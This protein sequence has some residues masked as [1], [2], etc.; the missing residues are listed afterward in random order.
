[1]R[2]TET[3]LRQ[4]MADVFGVGLD[5]IDAS[6]SIDSVESWDSLKHLNLVLALEERFGVSL[7]EHETV[8]IL[9]YELILAVLG[10]HR[11]EFEP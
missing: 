8:E 4:L 6:A 1:M 3:D 11:V 2:A 9:N 5:E 7:T 10:E